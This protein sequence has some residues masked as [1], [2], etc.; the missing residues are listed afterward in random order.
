M[1]WSL[2]GAKETAVV[3]ISDLVALIYAAFG[4]HCEQTSLALQS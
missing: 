2:F 1:L 4:H 3:D